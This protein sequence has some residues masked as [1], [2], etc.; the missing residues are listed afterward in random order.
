[1]D[2]ETETSRDWAKDVDTETSSRL[3]LISVGDHH[4]DGHPPSQGWSPSIQNLPDG[5]VSQTKFGT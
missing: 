1:M 4:Q 5:S 3:S 2:V